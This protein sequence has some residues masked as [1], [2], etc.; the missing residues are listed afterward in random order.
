MTF[1]SLYQ[2]IET[3]KT[4]KLT[5]AKVDNCWVIQAMT[6]RTYGIDRP[7][8]RIS[9]RENASYEEHLLRRVV[10]AHRGQPAPIS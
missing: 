3:N 1:P 7:C 6:H 10:E 4:Y 2:N 8:W 5:K 9:R